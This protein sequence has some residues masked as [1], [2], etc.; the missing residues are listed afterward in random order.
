[1]NGLREWFEQQSPRDRRVLLVGG[2]VLL[3][4]LVYALGLKPFNTHL[5]Q[6]RLAVDG[7]R[8]VLVQVQ[9]GVSEILARRGQGGGST[10]SLPAGSSLAQIVNQAA[11]EQQLTLSRMQP[12][13]EG[14][15][16][17]WLDDAEFDALLIW[18]GKLEGQYGVQVDSINISRG[19]VPGRVKVRVALKAGA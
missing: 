14:R 3:L 10:G 5:S 12:D 8:K 13:N 2:A 7:Q 6:A 15:L 19:E 11:G 17:L 16:Q 1:M 9:Q 18:L 4:G